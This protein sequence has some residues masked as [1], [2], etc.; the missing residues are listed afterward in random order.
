MVT[1][2]KGTTKSDLIDQM[3]REIPDDELQQSKRRG[4][5][6]GRNIDRSK[7]N[8]LDEDQKTK[9]ESLTKQNVQLTE[10]IA[11]MRSQ[12]SD[13]ETVLNGIDKV[14]SLVSFKMADLVN[15]AVKAGRHSDVFE[16]EGSGEQSQAER[17]WLPQLSEQ[18]EKLRQYEK[19]KK[20]QRKFSSTYSP[21]MKFLKILEKKGLQQQETD[22]ID[23]EVVPA[24]VMA[25]KL[26]EAICESKEKISKLALAL[27]FAGSQK[28][29]KELAS[30]FPEQYG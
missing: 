18:Y 20:A 25:H 9:L 8:L 5:S 28:K 23:K 30:K 3:L 12:I 22:D 17:D 6:T 13:M 29:E 10:T 19:Q 1:W 27:D 2:K 4:K 21:M 11:S 24:L 15:K 7:S 16:A 26:A 14:N